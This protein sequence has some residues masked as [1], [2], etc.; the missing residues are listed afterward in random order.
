MST[1]VLLYSYEIGD[2]ILLKKYFVTDFATNELQIFL[3]HIISLYNIFVSFA[4]NIGN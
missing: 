3:R 1:R 2:E 4:T